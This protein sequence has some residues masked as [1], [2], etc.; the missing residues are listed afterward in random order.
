MPLF[1]LVCAYAISPAFTL[2]I[3][4]GHPSE[5]GSG[6]TVHNGLR[7]VAVVWDI[8]Q[9]LRQELA[10]HPIKIVLTKRHEME[11]VTNARRAEIANKARADLLIRL[12]ADAGPGSGF[13]VYYPRKTGTANGISGPSKDVLE[14]SALAARAFFGPFSSA[15]KRQ[16]RSNGLRGDE[17]TLIGARQGALTGSILSKVPVLLVEMAFITDKKDAAWLAGD[18]NRHR[19]A[20]ALAAGVLAVRSGL[21]TKT[22]FAELTR[23]PRYDSIKNR[24]QPA[25]H[26]RR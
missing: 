23:T 9:R 14:E 22:A 4:P 20:K 7:E 19:M 12:H 6:N 1:L 5:N 11:F 18:R 13:T 25:A 26:K 24:R 15:L 10:D 16:L 3:D 17:R 8:S 2:C 21:R